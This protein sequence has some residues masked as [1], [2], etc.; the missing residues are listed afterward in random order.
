MTSS[1]AVIGSGIS[2]LTA[3]YALRAT[4][5]VTLFEADDRFGGHAHTHEIAEGD[6]THRV[7]TGFIVMNDRTY[8]ELQ[9]LFAELGVE[10]RPTEMSMSIRCDGCGLEF[11]G[12]RGGKGI[13]AQ[14]RRLFDV[15][16]VRMLLN[17]KRFQKLAL[18]LLDADDDG[19]APGEVLTYGDFLRRHAFDEYFLRHY[20]LPV[21]ACVW[22]SSNDDA[23]DYPA[24]YLFEFLK[25]HG[26]LSVKGS[27][28]W[29]TVV[30]GSG[31]YVDRVT[32]EI[33]DVRHSTRITGV[34]RKPDHVL[35]TDAT[36][37]THEFDKVVIATHADD[38]L[39]LLTDPSDEE[40][41]T[42]GA[43]GYSRN[44]TVLH[45]D[46]SLLPVAE[47]AKAAWNYRMDACAP[48]GTATPVTYW[49]NRLQGLT[50]APP[51]L[52]TLNG[53]DRLA[54]GSVVRTMQYTHPLY[55]PDSVAAQ[56]DLPALS[57]P[58]TVFAGAYHGWGFHEDGCRSGIAAARALGASW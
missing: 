29:Y 58:D 44:E 18:A 53:S 13:F 2:G 39:A 27:P 45:H 4:H 50:D 43:F 32:A 28:Q 23:R 10:I 8:P 51:F 21:V 19:V 17:I 25:H 20:A 49:M 14:K 54:D 48:S 40:T 26:F 1:V 31:T 38:A 3:A 22:S 16:Y 30:G 37:A 6:R 33:G 41:R 36:G 15:R 7:D 55:T 12:G 57:R 52:V 42:L 46:A 24:R 47:Q 5:Q 56:R 9:R 11:A 35:L 34:S